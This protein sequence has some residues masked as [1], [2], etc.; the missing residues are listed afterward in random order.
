MIRIKTVP[1]A[2]ISIVTMLGGIVIAKS[3]GYY[4]TTASKD[5]VKFKT[6]KLAGLPNPADIRGSYTWVDIEK[7]FKVPAAEAAAAFSGADH[8]LDPA[9]RV[10]ELETVYAG[11]LPAGLEIGTGA[12]R[13]FVSLYT[14]LPFEAEEGSVLPEGAL[15]LLATRPGMDAEAL[16]KFIIPGTSEAVQ[17]AAPRAAAPVTTLAPA[18]ANPAA[19]SASPASNAQTAPAAAPSATTAG[20]GSGSGSG[21]GTTTTTSGRAVV[22]KTSYGDLYDWGLTE[23]QIEAT[24]GFKPGSRTQSVREAAAAAGIEFSTFKTALQA[25]VDKTAP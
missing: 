1:L 19:A 6:G 5:P 17:G 23:A 11:I 8:A 4:E 2:I 21:T 25:L 12:V 3:V 20:T 22:G 13:L 16:R 18:A 7:A 9:S 24:T 14:G 15:A 10:S